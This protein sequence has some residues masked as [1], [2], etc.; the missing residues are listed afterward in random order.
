M[1]IFCIKQDIEL[2]KVGCL[3]G[4]CVVGDVQ[5]AAARTNTRLMDKSW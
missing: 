1:E 3:D 2:G 4:W 5:S